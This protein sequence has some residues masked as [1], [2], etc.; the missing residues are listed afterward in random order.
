MLL[1][2]YSTLLSAKVKVSEKKKE[3]KVKLVTL[4][5][6]GR[7]KVKSKNRAFFGPE[8]LRDRYFRATDQLF[9]NSDIRKFGPFSG[10][11]LDFNKY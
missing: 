9:R 6:Q 3:M 8:I 1:V 7:F 5:L 10:L 4:N 2:Q 11:N